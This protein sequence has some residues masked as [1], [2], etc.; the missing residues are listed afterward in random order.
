MWQEA[1]PSTVVYQITPR[2]ALV[3]NEPEDSRYAPSPPKL[4]DQ[5]R[6]ALRAKHYAHRTEETYL[7]W[8]KR[9]LKF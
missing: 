6:A 1:I 2:L 5:V 4:L 9:Y 3:I 7:N 8:I